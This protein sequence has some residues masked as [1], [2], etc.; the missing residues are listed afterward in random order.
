[1]AAVLG[2]WRGRGCHVV[3][4]NDYL[5]QRDAGWM[6]G[7]FK[8][9]GVSVGCV[10]GETETADRREAY[11]SDVTYS[12]G[13]EVCADFLRDRLVIQ[14]VGGDAR[15]YLGVVASAGGGGVAERL[16]QR[17]LAQVIVDEADSVLI[18]EA[19][20]PLILSGKSGG[21]AGMDD[22]AFEEA[23]GVAREM[24]EG[25]GY[26]VDRR[27]HEVKLTEQGRGAAGGLTR[28]A[29][30]RRR[31]EL[32]VEALMARELY[33]EGAEYV[34]REGKIVIVDEST[35]RLMEDRTWRAGM[36]Q[37]VEAK[38][39][40]EISAL[41]ETLAR[42]SYQRFFGM[43]GRIGG[44]SGTVREAAEEL[45][46]TYGLMVTRIPTNEKL[47]RVQHGDR[48][49]RDEASKLAAVA[50]EARRLSAEGR[51]VLIGTRS[52]ETSER[53]S[54]LLAG[55][56]IEHD[57]LNAVRHDEEAAIV[58]RAGR[59]GAVTVAT[60]MAGRGTDIRLEEAAREAGGLAVLATER[61]ATERLDRQLFGRAGRQ[62]DR[63]RR[64]R[65][66]RWR[67][68]SCGGTRG[69]WRGCSG[70]VRA[71]GRRAQ[72][73][74]GG[75]SC[76]WRRRALGARRRGGG[77][78]CGGR[79]TGWTTRWASLNRCSEKCGRSGHGER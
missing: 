9:C 31:E 40:L 10:V 44:M 36:H 62:G 23:A 17:G 14:H 20:T 3:T 42:V 38:E 52:V 12:T 48:V 45:W 66:C 78:L 71:R 56:R 75:V 55:L 65:L 32:L 76:G 26:T 49:F 21:A 19:V 22:E 73:G 50:D 33:R 46:R 54:G 15:A 35:G 2:G 57:V 41:T 51:P 16:V 74:G 27:R 11:G 72:V 1:M 37:A 67:T 79:T 63:D 64:A 60:N 77:V 59:A 18:D 61:H 24:N 58:A 25:E 5:A 39:G 53:V 29:S 7:V 70:S 47:A 30:A 8:R 34:V 43:Y 6:E 28:V 68:R 69:A 4:V 13:R